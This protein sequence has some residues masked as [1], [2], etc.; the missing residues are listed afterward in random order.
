MLSAALRT[1]RL[2]W[3]AFA[4]AFVALALGT[5][6]IA[7]TGLALAS[8]LDAP[9]QAPERFADAPAGGPP[10]GLCWWAATGG[11]PAGPP[12]PPPGGGPPGRAPAHSP[13]A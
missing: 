4:G 9:A 10:A 3:A 5:G 7:T 8:S 6:L 13:R 2:H 1:L 11:V 12:R